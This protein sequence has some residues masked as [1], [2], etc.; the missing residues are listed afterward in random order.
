MEDKKVDLWEGVFAPMRWS[1]GHKEEFPDP[2]QIVYLFSLT[3]KKKGFDPNAIAWSAGF[4]DEK[5]VFGVA[6][7]AIP[8]REA[9]IQANRCGWSIFCG[10]G[11][12]S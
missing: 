12:Q 2:D 9:F 5:G 11:Y 4:E 7:V 8:L 10:F 1:D 6:E 3:P